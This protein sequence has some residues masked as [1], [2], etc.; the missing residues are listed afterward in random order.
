[1]RAQGLSPINRLTPT[2]S[3]ILG[4]QRTAGNAAV[5]R[6]LAVQRFAP[7]A[8]YNFATV[9]RA[10]LPPS[11]ELMDMGIGKQERHHVIGDR[12]ILNWIGPKGPGDVVPVNKWAAAALKS[13]VT[14]AA[15]AIAAAEKDDRGD[16]T[17]VVRSKVAL[18]KAY[19]PLQA[20]FGDGPADE[21]TPVLEKDDVDYLMTV[22]EWTPN[23][24]IIDKE[25]RR[26]DPGDAL[27]I[28]ALLLK[29]D[30]GMRILLFKIAVAMGEIEEKQLTDLD[31]A[32][33]KTKNAAKWDELRAA[34]K[35]PGSVS[36]L[37]AQL[38]EME[39]SAARGKMQPSK[40]GKKQKLKAPEWHA[41]LI[42]HMAKTV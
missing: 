6:M 35:D 9:K 11:V 17:K 25:A 33:K 26:L 7:Q 32:L 5:Q 24:F 38:I 23:N 21:A 29:A 3:A 36:A 41:L 10:S 8:A 4:L 20:R 27:D 30:V 13:E 40:T 19:Q 18:E 28:E 42:K 16:E 14:R 22:L 37:F 2:V 31:D 39:P 12:S 1:V 34:L 15:A